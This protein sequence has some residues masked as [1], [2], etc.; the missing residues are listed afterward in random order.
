MADAE[1]CEHGVDYAEFCEPC[2]HHPQEEWVGYPMTIC[3]WC[4]ERWPCAWSRANV[5]AAGPENPKDR[6]EAR[7]LRESDCEEGGW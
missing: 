7:L 1:R 4:Q 2:R 6:Q 3:P 5:T